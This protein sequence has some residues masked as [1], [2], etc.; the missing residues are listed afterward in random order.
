MKLRKQ[1]ISLSETVICKGVPQGSILE[2]MCCNYA[3]QF[4]IV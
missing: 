1:F 3:Y 4:R 2:S